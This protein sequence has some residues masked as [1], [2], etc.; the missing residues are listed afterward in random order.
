MFMLSKRRIIRF[1][2]SVVIVVSCF[3]ICIC[4]KLMYTGIMEPDQCANL[5]VRGVL[6]REESRDFVLTRGE[7]I[8]ENPTLGPICLVT[9]NNVM[10]HTLHKGKGKY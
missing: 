5:H 9:V 7:G 2:Y 4:S 10:K 6:H 3:Y 1:H 8:F